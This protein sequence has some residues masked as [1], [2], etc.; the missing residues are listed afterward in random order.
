MNSPNGANATTNLAVTSTIGTFA[1]TKPD[2]TSR[3][4]LSVTMLQWQA[5][6][7]Q[8]LILL[9]HQRPSFPL[10]LPRRRRT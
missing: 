10:H 2:G 8:G 5:A 3:K 9:Q 7:Y 1:P 6:R 4:I